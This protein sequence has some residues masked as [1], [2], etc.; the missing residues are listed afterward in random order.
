MEEV[1][2]T[3][4]DYYQIQSSAVNN[5]VVM[6]A[7]HDCFTVECI[8]HSFLNFL[9]QKNYIVKEGKVFKNEKREEFNS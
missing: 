8:I 1:K 5:Y 2:L 4:K 6:T 7:Q 9:N 3:Y